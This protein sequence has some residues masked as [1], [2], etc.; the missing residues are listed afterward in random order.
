MG[1]PDAFDVDS[2]GSVDNSGANRAYHQIG[3]SCCV[4][5]SSA[6]SQDAGRPASVAE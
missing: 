6:R 5:R 3:A 2:A 4:R 1:F